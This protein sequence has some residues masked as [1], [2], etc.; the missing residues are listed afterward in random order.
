MLPHVARHTG[1]EVPGT[2]FDLIPALP[3]ARRQQPLSHQE[4]GKIT[5]MSIQDRDLPPT[6][7]CTIGSLSEA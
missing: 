7:H 4:M 3:P 2:I 5:Q 6:L 1:D